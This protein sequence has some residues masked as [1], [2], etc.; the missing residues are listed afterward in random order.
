M[1]R[2]V[3]LNG[4]LLRGHMKMEDHTKVTPRSDIQM[5]H[6]GL[7]TF[8]TDTNLVGNLCVQ[9]HHGSRDP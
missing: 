5:S 6:Q 1:N 8:T 4:D 9:A 7:R 3:H 2:P